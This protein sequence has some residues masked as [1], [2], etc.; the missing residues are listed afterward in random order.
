MAADPGYGVY[1]HLVILAY[2]LVQALKR[3]K[4]PFAWAYTTIKQLRYHIIHVAGILTRHAR[5]WFLHLGKTYAHI[6]FFE[7]ILCSGY[8]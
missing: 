1:F 6:P 5:G 2:N 8:S 3:I 7:R 4:L